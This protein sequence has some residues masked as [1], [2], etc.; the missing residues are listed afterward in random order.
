MAFLQIVVGCKDN[1]QQPDIKLPEPQIV[2]QVELPPSLDAVYYLISPSETGTLVLEEL[3]ENGFELVQAWVPIQQ[4]PCDCAT[5]VNA[6][7]VELTTADE[8]IQEFDF[9][10]DPEPWVVNCGVNSFEY[11]D[12]VT[13]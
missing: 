13:Q 2:D 3:L 7:I 6:I 4:T 12:F 8:R 5:C 1:P 10:S 9:I 11:F